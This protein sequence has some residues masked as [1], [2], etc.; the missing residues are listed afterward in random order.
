MENYS[1]PTSLSPYGNAEPGPFLS[2]W[3]LPDKI[4]DYRTMMNLSN[5]ASGMANQK[6]RNELNEF[7]L[8]SG[9]RGQQ[10]Q[11]TGMQLGSQITDQPLQAQLA[12]T[13]LQGDVKAAPKLNEAKIWEAMMKLPKEQQDYALGQFH[14]TS[15]LLKGITDKEWETADPHALLSMLQKA[16]IDTSDWMDPKTGQFKKDPQTI[17]SDLKHIQGLDPEFFKE[18]HAD[19]RANETNQTHLT[20][21]REHNAT[22]R[23][24]A[25]TLAASRIARNSSTRAAYDANLD[26]Q[27]HPILTKLND[28]EKVDTI[29]PDEWATLETWQAA[30][31]E[32]N[33]RQGAIAQGTAD[34]A[35]KTLESIQPSKPGQTPY[36]P[37]TLPPSHG[38]G[39][40][41][42]KP[43]GPPQNPD[44]KTM[45]SM[46]DGDL[47][48]WNGQPY[49]K[50][51]K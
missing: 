36:K 22:S 41:Q 30:R 18:A 25:D 5:D 38:G 15:G 33:A 2:G 29:T 27:V 44:Q 26:A 16:Q 43:K 6:S 11:L 23:Y 12:N 13:N 37:N 21:G 28:P 8:N 39:G 24:V 34:K 48:Y 49:H 47:Y 40:I 17:K 20:M 10:R 46:K 50:G 4:N 19:F 45:D 14:R 35:K 1:N 3:M 9:L 32:E 42:A 31:K 7:A 51:V